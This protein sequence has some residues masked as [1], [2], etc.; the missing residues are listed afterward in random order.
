[1]TAILRRSVGLGYYAQLVRDG[2]GFKLKTKSLVNNTTSEWFTKGVF[3]MVI[4][5]K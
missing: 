1:M 4:N 5:S 3:D 2:P